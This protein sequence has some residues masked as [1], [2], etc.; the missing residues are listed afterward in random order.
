MS[1]QTSRS[2]ALLPTLLLC[3]TLP[4]A[5][6]APPAL[7][8]AQALVDQGRPQAALPLLDTLLKKEPG[9]ARALLLR[10]TARYL[11][12]DPEGGRR[13]LDQ[14]LTLDPGLRQGWLNR[15]GI[16]IADKRYDAALAAL[17]RAE[18][19]DPRAADNDVNI[20]AVLLL[21]GKLEPASGRFQSYLAKQ[22]GKADATYLVATNYAMAGY[23]A[24][25]IEHLRQAVALDEL[26]RLRARADRNFAGL[27]NNPRF[28]ELMATDAWKPP[29]GSLL[30]S[31]AFDVPYREEDGMLLGA[32]LDA[33][34]ATGER[35]DPRIESAPDWA[36]V[37][38]Q[39]RVKVSRTADGKGLV[40]ASTPA[41]RLTAAEWRQRTDRLFQQVAA[42]LL[43]RQRA[44]LKRRPEP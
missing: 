35:Y 23:A 38:G 22:P 24:L 27:A 2:H 41:G 6:Q 36:L 17:E 3:V 40:E 42:E 31:R 21:Q 11:T 14:A 19:L 39:M 32:V 7:D 30:A 5:A 12:E 43:T 44:N 15:A 20:G 26:Q 29:A 13:D 28:R 9:N 34:R 18:Q 4:L 8:Q 25:A 1:S 16:A 37:R 10:S 33:L